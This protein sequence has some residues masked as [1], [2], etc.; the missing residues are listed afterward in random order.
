[1][2]V[3]LFNS[4]RSIATIIGSYS[5]QA[6]N[7]W[8]LPWALACPCLVYK[9]CAR[10]DYVKSFLLLNFTVCISF[11]RQFVHCFRI[12]L[13]KWLSS[14][15]FG[16]WLPFPHTSFLRQLYGWVAIHLKSIP[17]FYAPT[18]T[19]ISKSTAWSPCYRSRATTLIWGHITPR[20]H[21]VS[22]GKIVGCH[23]LWGERRWS[24]HLP[25]ARMLLTLLQCTACPSTTKKYP[26]QK[27]RGADV[28][29]SYVRQGKSTSPSSA[30]SY[31]GSITGVKRG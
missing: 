9:E 14:L 4:W 18:L 10:C 15:L 28:E 1:M 21:M 17:M 26:V 24:W 30:L 20:G 8:L 11:Q 2:S 23:N 16:L 7:K 25:K 29:K 3:D 22:S 5:L 27:V 19:S 13:L 12:V 6:Q 31:L